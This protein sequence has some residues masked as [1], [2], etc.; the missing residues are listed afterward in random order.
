MQVKGSPSDPKWY[1]EHGQAYNPGFT[2]LRTVPKKSPFQV[3]PSHAGLT[4]ALLGHLR[5]ENIARFCDIEGLR[6]SHQWLLKFATEG[7]VPTNGA[8]EES[9]LRADKFQLRGWPV[10]E[11]IGVP[12]RVVQVPFIRANSSV[13][14]IDSFWNIPM[15]AVRFEAPA[16][17]VLPDYTC[18]E[19]RYKGEKSIR[20]KRQKLVLDEENEEEEEE[21]EGDDESS[22]SQASW[23]EEGAEI[24]E[25]KEWGPKYQLCVPG[26]YAI[27][28]VE[29]E[30]KG[31]EPEHHGITVVQVLFFAG[32]GRHTY[33]AGVHR[34]S[35]SYPD[36]C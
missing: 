5:G 36:A 23:L 4:P 8:V 6:G 31:K 26:H 19:V 9:M 15:E 34:C 25:V 11:T 13:N 24:K 35:W 20:S 3:K 7:R 2:M 16:P 30:A 27:C 14:D 32:E 18:P 1:G 22:D 21:E 17:V 10:V 33:G 12:P 28:E 29:Y